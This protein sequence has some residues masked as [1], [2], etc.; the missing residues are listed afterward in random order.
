MYMALGSKTVVK[1][2]PFEQLDAMKCL[3]LKD[4]IEI[5]TCINSNTTSN[6][7]QTFFKMIPPICCHLK[8]SVFGKP[9][10]TCRKTPTENVVCQI[11][12]FVFDSLKDRLCQFTA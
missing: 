11:H 7:F 10:Q 5:S 4:S 9:S 8:F 3:T 1:R 2:R 6:K 12:V